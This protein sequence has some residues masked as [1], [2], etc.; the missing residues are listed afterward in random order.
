MKDVEDGGMMR[1][2]MTLKEFEEAVE[3]EH[4]RRGLSFTHLYGK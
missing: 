1:E 3:R 2:G 4:K